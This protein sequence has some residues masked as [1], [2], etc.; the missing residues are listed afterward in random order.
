MDES[1]WSASPWNFNPAVWDRRSGQINESGHVSSLVSHV[2][3]LWVA[4]KLQIFKAVRTQGGM[5]FTNSVPTTATEYEWARA[6]GSHMAAPSFV[7]TGW[8]TGMNSMLWAALYTPIGL[9]EETS[10]KGRSTA[11][12][13]ADPVGFLR[14]AL[15]FGGLVA[16]R[17]RVLPNVGVHLFLNP[18]CTKSTT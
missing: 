4:M 7:E 12:D 16:M 17:E 3:L 15:D 5:L 2:T 14:M 10:S 6:H 11:P 9:A 8:S 13:G 1:A 18:N